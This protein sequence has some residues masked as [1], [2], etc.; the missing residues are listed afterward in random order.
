MVPIGEFGDDI[1]QS[2]PEFEIL[3]ELRLGSACASTAAALR[4][5][6]RYAVRGLSTPTELRAFSRKALGQFSSPGRAIAPRNSR[7]ARRQRRRHQRWSWKCAQTNTFSRGHGRYPLYR[8]VHF[9]QALG[10]GNDGLILVSQIQLA[11]LGLSSKKLGAFPQSCGGQ[12]CGRNVLSLRHEVFAA[13]PY[14]TELPLTSTSWYLL[15]WKVGMNIE[16]PKGNR[17]IIR[18]VIFGP[19]FD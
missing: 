5:Q 7:P 12:Q 6:Q 9:N 4:A 19:T 1:Q 8:Q 15:V 14:K 2:A 10:V 13:M 11:S 17:K 16:V 18:R 3:M